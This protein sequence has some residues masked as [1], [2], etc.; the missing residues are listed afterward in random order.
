MKQNAAQ[1]NVIEHNDPPSARIHPCDPVRSDKVESK[2]LNTY[3]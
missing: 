1:N 2:D 3:E